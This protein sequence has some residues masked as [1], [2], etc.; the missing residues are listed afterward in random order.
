[1]T[2]TINESAIEKLPP[3]ECV[4][5]CKK[6]NRGCFR[7]TEADAWKCYGF[8]YWFTL[9]LNSYWFISDSYIINIA[10]QTTKKYFYT[11]FTEEETP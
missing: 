11:T 4:R 1:M 9:I 2:I 3:S 5:R 6:N 7:E 10:D 8:P